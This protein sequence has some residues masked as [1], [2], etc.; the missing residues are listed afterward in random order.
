MNRLDFLKESAIIIS[1]AQ[2]IGKTYRAE[3][4]W[5]NDKSDFTSILDKSNNLFAET[6]AMFNKNFQW[7]QLSYD[8]QDNIQLDL[9][10]TNWINKKIIGTEKFSWQVVNHTYRSVIDWVAKCHNKTVWI[11]PLSYWSKKF[12]KNYHNDVQTFTDI[13]EITAGSTVVLDLPHRG[14][15]QVPNHLQ[16][17]LSHCDK[18]NV[19]VYVD[20]T[21]LLISK[22]QILDLSNN[23][24]K[25]INVSFSKLWPVA[26]I[27]STI[28]GYKESQPRGD[29]YNLQKLMCKQLCSW[30]H[31]FPHNE[32][33]NFLESK[34]LFWCKFLDLQ[35]SDC[36]LHADADEDLKT[37]W[38]HQYW[39]DENFTEKQICL[40]PLYENKSLIV[41]YFKNNLD[42]I[43]YNL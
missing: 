33:I 34:Q 13:N 10:F 39:N 37:Y 42:G 30:M 19:E 1:Y 11:D 9:T 35:P 14:T 23:C 5:H 16:T 6:R 4:K 8:W 20:T 18:N 24:V 25:C 2:S 31:S 17:L 29:S 26:G 22:N 38:T 28:A 12:L 15:M 27:G 36:V 3:H 7:N 40:V 21:F 41:N 32:Y 43:V